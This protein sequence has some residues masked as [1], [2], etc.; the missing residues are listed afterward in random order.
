VRLVKTIGDAAM[1]AS[2]E[3]EPMLGTALSL[4][5][6]AES[7]GEDFPQL[8]RRRGYRPGAAAP[9]ATGSASP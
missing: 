9:P 1:L 8:R 2:P 5:D 4:I 7:E 3:P 6:A